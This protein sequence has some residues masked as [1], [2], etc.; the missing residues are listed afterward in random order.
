[1][2]IVQKHK[3]KY[4]Y[5]IE[6]ELDILYEVCQRDFFAVLIFSDEVKM[7]NAL[8]CKNPV[9]GVAIHEVKILAF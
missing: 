2:I 5:H 8:R 9:F 7:Q 1:M 4:Y 3:N 6:L